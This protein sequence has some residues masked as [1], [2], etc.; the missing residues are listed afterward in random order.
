MSREL[1]AL[2][3][4]FGIM[5]YYTDKRSV[6]QRHLPPRQHTVGKL[7]M[8]MIER[9]HLMLRTRFKRLAHKTLY[10]SRACGMHD[11]IIGLYMNHVEF[12]CTV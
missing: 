12:G 3:A 5:R 9:K 10:F 6:E 4:P 11:L 8:Q 7:T 1:R 2:L